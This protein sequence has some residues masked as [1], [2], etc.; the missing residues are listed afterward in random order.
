MGA[1]ARLS[2]RPIETDARCSALT[3]SRAMIGSLRHSG[4]VIG[5][6][7]TE[8]SRATQRT[9]ELNIIHTGCLPGRLEDWAPQTSP[10]TD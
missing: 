6:N 4:L 7:A 1:G 9:A 8:R 10:V 5:R 3:S 2:R